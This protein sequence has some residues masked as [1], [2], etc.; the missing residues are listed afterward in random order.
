MAN[1]LVINSSS[2]GAQIYYTTDGSDPTTSSTLYE[3]GIELTDSVLIKAVGVKENWI[4]SD[5]AT[6]N[7]ILQDF[8]EFTIRRTTSTTAVDYRTYIF[9]VTCNNAP[10]NSEFTLRILINPIGSI[11][12]DPYYS[13]IEM[14]QTSSTT[15]EGSFIQIFNS[16]TERSFDSIIGKATGYKPLKIN[17]YSS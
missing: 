12:Q 4:D 5:I 10:Q 13:N 16:S 9:T 3:P 2:S 7:L 8:P 1:E 15:W 17:K 14:E 6:Y 11:T